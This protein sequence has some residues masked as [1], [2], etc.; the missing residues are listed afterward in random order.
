MHNLTAVHLCYDSYSESTATLRFDC[1]WTDVVVNNRC[2]PGS[3]SEESCHPMWAD[4][5]TILFFQDPFWIRAPFLSPH[6]LADRPVSFLSELDFVVSS[7]SRITSK[8]RTRNSAHGLP[9][10]S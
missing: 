4:S 9:A 10:G 1:A 2:V 6:I 7:C 3:R 8:V 5:W